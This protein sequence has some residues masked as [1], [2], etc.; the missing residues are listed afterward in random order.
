MIFRAAKIFS[1]IL[2]ICACSN[3]SGIEES[4]IIYDAKKNEN[5]INLLN[6]QKV[7]Y[8]VQDDGLIFYPVEQKDIVIKAFEKTTGRKIPEHQPSP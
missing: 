5:F 7:D 2:L 1:L 3:S 6:E 4:I 8:R